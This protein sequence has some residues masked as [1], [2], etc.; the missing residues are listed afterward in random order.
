[1]DQPLPQRLNS[2]L[3]PPLAIMLGASLMLLSGC[4]KPN[5]ESLLEDYHSRLARVLPLAAPES[6]SDAKIATAINPVV[7]LAQPAPL[8]AIRDIRQPLADIRLD[9]LDLVALR[10]CD[11]QQ[12]VAERNSSLGKVMSE[13]NRFAYEWSLLIKIQPCLQHPQLASS[14]QQQLTQIFTQKQLQLPK[15]WQNVLLTDPTLRQ[16]LQGSQRSL[17]VGA[18]QRI[19][20][21]LQALRQLREFQTLVMTDSTSLPQ[22]PITA[23]ELNAQLALL[24]QGQVLADLQYS[25]QWSVRYWQQINQQLAAVALEPWCQRART[26]GQLEILQQVFSQIYLGRV[27]PYFAELDGINHQLLPELQALYQGTLL[28]DAITERYLTPAT[29]L[30]AALQQH[31]YWWQ[32]LQQQCRMQLTPNNRT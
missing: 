17:T 22:R 24:Y 15:V 5:A 2:W 28:Q 3:K 25:L 26:N 18:T 30:R 9:L 13:A 29:A 6:T 27:Q 31:V 20:P 32:Q 21:T 14:L 11:L 19:S 16:Q 23:T 4:S 1:M 10:H 8:P 7:P 12:L